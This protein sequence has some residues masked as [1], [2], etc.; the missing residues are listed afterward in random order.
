MRDAN[1]I[2]YQFSTK[3]IHLPSREIKIGD[4]RKIWNM[5][6]V[7]VKESADLQFNQIEKPADL[8]EEEFRKRIEAQ[9][10]SITLN[11]FI[12][13]TDGS[14][15]LFSGEEI[16]EESKLPSEI[17]TLHLDNHSIHKQNY[18]FEPIHRFDLVIDFRKQKILDF[19][20]PTKSSTLNL[21]M[22]TISGS[23]STWVNGLEKEVFDFFKEKQ[24]NR[25]WLFKTSTYNVYQWGIA[26]PIVFW[27]LFRLEPSIRY[28]NLSNLLSIAFYLYTSLLAYILCQIFFTYI[29]WI[30]PY[31]EMV[32]EGGKSKKHRKAHLFLISGILLAI[33]YDILKFLVLN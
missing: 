18:G 7:K 32:T 27:I 22:L 5:L 16:F 2:N 6:L 19:S 12:L 21:S 15:R 9:R 11:G 24:K 20:T 26:I 17:Q 28:M 1:K 4:L 33:I 31:H 23:N 8:S 3:N 10:E 13:G 30:F 25:N 14:N 29:K